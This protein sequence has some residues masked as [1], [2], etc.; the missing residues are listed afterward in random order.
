MTE[1]TVQLPIAGENLEQ[2]DDKIFISLMKSIGLYDIKTSKGKALAVVTQSTS[3]Q[4]TNGEICAQ[5][6]IAATDTV[7]S[8]TMLTNFQ[9]ALQAKTCSS[10][11]QPLEKI[12]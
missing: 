4:W 7:V 12:F 5:A 3:L 6:I 1:I 10:L 9:I 2:A 8:L 11:D